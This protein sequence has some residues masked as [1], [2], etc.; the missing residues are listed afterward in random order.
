MAV[1]DK[2]LELGCHCAV[3]GQY[4]ENNQRDALCIQF[5]KN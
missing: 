3:N 5:I 1:E 2:V 4:S